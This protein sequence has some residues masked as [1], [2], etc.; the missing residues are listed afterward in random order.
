MGTRA[1]TGPRE[2]KQRRR[3][4]G[5]RGDWP[6]LPLDSPRWPSQLWGGELP[7][8][9]RRSHRKL[10]YVSKV[11]QPGSNAW[12]LSLVSGWRPCSPP[13]KRPASSPL[14][15]LNVGQARSALGRRHP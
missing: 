3:T 15:A 6:L 12:E 5:A 7:T 13:A 11:T 1:L 8:F 10:H 9:P 4:E 2:G 14:R